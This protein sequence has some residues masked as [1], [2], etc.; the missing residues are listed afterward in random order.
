MCR[1]FD[2][3]G[4]FAPKVVGDLNLA[5]DYL[6]FWNDPQGC[7]LKVGAAI[8]NL[9]KQI[10]AR[11]LLPDISKGNDS[12]QDYIQVLAER[13]I[14]PKK[15]MQAMEYIRRR[16]NQANHEGWDNEYD[17]RECLKQAHRIM[18]WCVKYYCLGEPKEYK[19]PDNLY[20]PLYGI[21]KIALSN[22]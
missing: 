6:Y 5:E 22:Y 19:Q 13:G 8:E 10:G 7:M 20:K 18:S 3:A 2:F 9:V 17:A 4:G 11:Q 16:R 14:L 1:N 12:F 21:R 15:I